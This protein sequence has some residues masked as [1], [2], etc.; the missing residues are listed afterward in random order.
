MNQF[1]YNSNDYIPLTYPE[2]MANVSA[3]AD[4]AGLLLISS[5]CQLYRTKFQSTDVPFS[6]IEFYLEE[7]SHYKDKLNPNIQ[8]FFENF[9][10]DD[11]LEMY[12]RMLNFSTYNVAKGIK[13]IDGY[14]YLQLDPKNNFYIEDYI[15][16]PTSLNG[17]VSATEIKEYSDKYLFS[18]ELKSLSEL[19]DDFLIE[20]FIENYNN[21]EHHIKQT[22]TKENHEDL[23]IKEE[24]ER[25]NTTLIGAKNTIPNQKGKIVQLNIPRF[26]LPMSYPIDLNNSRVISDRRARRF[27][28]ADQ[29]IRLINAHSITAI[30]FSIGFIEKRKAVKTKK[31]NKFDF[32]F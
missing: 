30:G 31:T 24:T 14:T 5:A 1:A 19:Y 16:R 8:E 23:K 27:V 3:D 18:D 22:T 20:K 11:N 25:L 15:E 13:K 32:D 7:M 26:K 12:I 17:Q 9:K 4:N 21:V 6:F 29:C 28:S 2:D 10:K